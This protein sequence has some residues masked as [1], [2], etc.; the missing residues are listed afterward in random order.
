MRIAFDLDGVV[1]NL[2]LAILRWLNYIKDEHIRDDIMKYY[3][4][5][6]TIQ[7]NPLDYIAEGDELYFITGRDP[8]LSDITQKWTRKYFPMANLIMVQV[9]QPTIEV[10]IDWLDQ[11][12]KGKAVVINEKQ[13]DVYFDDNPSVVAKLRQMC[14]NTKIIKYGGRID[15]IKFS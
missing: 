13:I 4:Y 1:L 5:H 11:Q 12:A 9:E 15:D 2:D 3:C 10:S 6:K 8:I 7:L 14:P